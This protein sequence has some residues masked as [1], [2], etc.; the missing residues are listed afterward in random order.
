AA[1]TGSGR[2][3]DVDR[4][5]PE[6]DAADPRAVGAAVRCD[7]P[8][9]PLAPSPQAGRAGGGDGGHALAA[10]ARAVRPLAAG[11]LDAAAPA[12]GGAQSRA[13]GA[14]DGGR[15]RAAAFVGDDPR[16]DA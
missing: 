13:G 1:A 11:F 6:L 8:R 5:E 7:R 12:A 15:R 14:H 16:A 4:G 2:P 9:T 10:G 3:L